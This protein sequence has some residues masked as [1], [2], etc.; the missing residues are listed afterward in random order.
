[1]PTELKMFY[2]K[3]RKAWRR[4]LQKYHKKEPGVWLIYYKKNSGKSHVS[5]DDAVEEAL[6]FG[7]I[8]SIMKPI[9]EE[10]YMQKFTPRKVKSGWSALNKRRV[11]QM[12][13]QNFMTPAG[14]AIIDLGKQNGSWSKLDDVEN[15]VIPPDLARVFAKNKKVL[16]YF[17]G[18]AKFSRKQW[19]YR[20]TNA[21]RPETRAKRL[22]EIIDATKKDA[23]RTKRF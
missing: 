6:C 22:K 12:I 20:L 5:C 15:S 23:L 1:M 7:W 14:M 16:K 21:K 13:E 2:P 3:D 19:L 8:D 11:E 4:W 18:L 17:E 9:D 10:K